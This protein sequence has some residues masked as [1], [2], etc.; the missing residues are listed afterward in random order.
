[1]IN[2]REKERIFLIKRRHWFFLFTSILS[3]AFFFIIFIILMIALVFI[4]ISWPEW[5]ESISPFNIKMVLVFLISLFLLFIWT[6]M[7]VVFTH[8]YLDCWIVT[9]ERTIHTELRGFFSR[10]FSSVNHDKIQDITVDVRG[11]FATIFK[12]GDLHIQ[13]AGEF[14]E[15]VC[16]HI[17]DP[18]QT[19]EIIFKAQ[20]N[21]NE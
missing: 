9:N 17:P 13:T 5:A 3:I 11:F 10:I 16:R 8:Y 18:Y 19:K 6:L 21:N 20:K 14:R 4:P 1:M 7:F 15:Y 2:L 12:F